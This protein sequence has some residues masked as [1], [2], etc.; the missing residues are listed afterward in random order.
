MSD[1]AS[2]CV[3]EAAAERQQAYLNFES[4]W[5]LQQLGKVVSV[6]SCQELVEGRHQMRCEC[7]CS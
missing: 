4:T 6:G 1:D 3:A 7:H 5:P 2:S